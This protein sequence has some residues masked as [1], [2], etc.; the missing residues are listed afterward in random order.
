VLRVVDHGSAVFV[1]FSGDEPVASYPEVDRLL[2][3][4]TERADL[5]KRVTPEQ[6]RDRQL[7]ARARRARSK[8]LRR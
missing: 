8:A 6:H 1:V 3:D 2:A 7:R 4:L 5:A